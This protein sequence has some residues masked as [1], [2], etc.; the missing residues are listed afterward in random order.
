[1]ICEKGVRPKNDCSPTDWLSSFREGPRSA[2][3]RPSASDFKSRTETSGGEVRELACSDHSC[4]KET[5]CRGSALAV[6]RL[7][8]LRHSVSLLSVLL[9]VM[10]NYGDTC[11]RV[12][13]AS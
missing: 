9:N 13:R 6:E 1:M 7:C 2:V 4:P 3:L 10:L 5:L 12:Y 8:F 11:G